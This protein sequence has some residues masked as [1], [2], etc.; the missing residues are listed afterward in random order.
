[1]IALEIYVRLLVP[2]CNRG[3][4]SLGTRLD[5]LCRSDRGFRGDM[6]DK[7]GCGSQDQGRF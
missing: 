1:M 4:G 5:W 2:N 6:L 3:F 7:A